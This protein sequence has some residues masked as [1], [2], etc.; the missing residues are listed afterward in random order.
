MT[1]HEVE[2]LLETLADVVDAQPADHP[3]RRVD[4]DTSRIYET[5]ETLD[6]QSPLYTRKGDLEKANYVGVAS[7]TTDPTPAGPNQRYELVA[8]ASIR[9][10]ALTRDGGTYGHVHPEGEDGAPTFDA[11]FRA[12][13]DAVRAEMSYPDVGRPGVAYRDLT[14]TTIDEQ[15]SDDKDFYRA[16]FDVQ[17]R[18]YTDTP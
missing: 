5:G 4:R 17:F 15:L 1:T 2:Y 9:L 11:L 10:E 13:F 12:V 8:T 18:G 3:L 14:I 16:E 6:M 7:Q